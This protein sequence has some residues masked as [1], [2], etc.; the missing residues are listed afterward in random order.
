[1]FGKKPQSA[2]GALSDRVRA[3][4]E[5]T[6]SAPAPRNSPRAPRRRVFRN[7]SILLD[8][9]E[10]YAVAITDVSETGAR[11]EFFHDLPLAEEF[12]L[13]E[14]MMQLRRRARLAWRSERVAG[15][16]FVD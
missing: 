5:R 4:A 6:P 9:G 11:I 16:A 12:T 10:R 1:M 15:V 8:T 2:K 3:I 14:P 13:S 7:G